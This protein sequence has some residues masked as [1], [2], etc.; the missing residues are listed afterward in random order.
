MW[1]FQGSKT[2]AYYLRHRN[3]LQQ[4][5]DDLGVTLD[6]VVPTAMHQILG[7]LKAVHNAGVVHRDVKPLNIVVDEEARC[8]KLIDLGAAADLR[9]GMN[10]VPD[11]SII[12][13]NYCAPEQFVLPTDTVDLSEQVP[14]CASTSR[15]VSR[16]RCMSFRLC[17]SIAA[18]PVIFSL[19]R[20]ASPSDLY[21]PLRHSSKSRPRCSHGSN[22]VSHLT[23]PAS[24]HPVCARVLRCIAHGGP[25]R[26]ICLL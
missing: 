1:E 7:C 9:T 21:L 18:H 20:L 22:L 17:S 25:L 2:L 14:P 11:E 15:S 8:L 23:P 6:S 16:S 12:D 26:P 13:P 19:S 3:G 4:L 10:Y 5:A 24:D